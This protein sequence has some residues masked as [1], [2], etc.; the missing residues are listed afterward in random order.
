MIKEGG[1][2]D[3]AKTLATEFQD[4][5]VEVMFERARDQGGERHHPRQ[6]A[7][8]DEEEGKGQPPERVRHQRRFLPRLRARAEEPAG[9]QG[10]PL[11]RHVP[12]RLRRQRRSG[13]RQG[14]GQARPVRVP[15]PGAR[16][17]AWR[18]SPPL[19]RRAARR[20]QG[21]RQE[22]CR[23]STPT[24][25]ASRTSRSRCR[26]RVAIRG[27]PFKPGDEVARHFP[28]VLVDG[29]PA[30]FS[31]GSGRQEL[32]EAIVQAADRDAGDRQPGL[33]VALR[34]AGW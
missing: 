1:S 21:A 6:G 20:H 28:S 13:Q 32:A 8:R 31:K 25:T 7:A 23:R 16:S 9:R 14:G 26:C 22:R 3:E 24:C 19:Y 27:N 15:R 4:L 29:D 10:V 18:R 17:L 30:P 33:E 12:E 34:H 2:E 5:V 11:R